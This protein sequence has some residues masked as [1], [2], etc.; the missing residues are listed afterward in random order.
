MKRT[1]DKDIGVVA[2]AALLHFSLKQSLITIVPL[3]IKLEQLVLLVNSELKLKINFRALIDE[4]KI[5]VKQTPLA[6]KAEQ[7]KQLGNSAEKQ[8]NRQSIFGASVDSS[9]KNDL[10][11]IV[12]EGE[13]SLKTFS[14][15]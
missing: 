12:E 14:K 15:S 13:I 7:W 8:F 4:L 10:D 9:N 1:E 11:I 3:I 6:E 5:F 2:Y